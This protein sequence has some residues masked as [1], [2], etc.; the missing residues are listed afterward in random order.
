M[1]NT[2][3]EIAKFFLNKSW[4][5]FALSIVCGFFTS[6]ALIPTE[7]RDS[8]P[9]QNKDWSVVATIVVTSLAFYLLFYLIYWICRKISDRHHYSKLKK[10]NDAYDNEQAKIN[11]IHMIDCW[12]ESDYQ[13][14]M[15]LITNNNKPI[16]R[17]LMFGSNIRPNWFKIV[18]AK[19]TPKPRKQSGKPSQEIRGSGAV[20]IS[21]KP[22]I[23]AFL[24][25][26]YDEE[27]SLTSEYRQVF[28]F[29]EDSKEKQ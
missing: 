23:Y 10:E 28:D 14:L 4:V 20:M 6:V 17:F 5:V 27:G 24:K 11:I 22:D 25:Q 18:P 15:K 3:G 19:E 29:N 13:D 1:S 26:I 21:L 16:K 9:F 12:N 8:I 7:W 2:A